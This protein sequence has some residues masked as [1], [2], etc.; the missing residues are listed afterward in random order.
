MGVSGADRACFSSRAG[1]RTTKHTIIMSRSLVQTW[2]KHPAA[3]WLS[4]NTKLQYT[5]AICARWSV[6]QKLRSACEVDTI[7]TAAA[8]VVVEVVGFG[9]ERSHLMTGRFWNNPGANKE[10]KGSVPCAHHLS[11]FRFFWETLTGSKCGDDV[12]MRLQS[13]SC[14]CQWLRGRQESSYYQTPVLAS[15]QNKKLQHLPRVHQV[16]WRAPTCDL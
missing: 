4:T 3:S 15:N 9:V 12:W 16:G 5:V 6:C 11:S 7:M 10:R 2:K 14:T 8:E 1:W 13:T